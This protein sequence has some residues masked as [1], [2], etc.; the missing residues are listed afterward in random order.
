MTAIRGIPIPRLMSAG[1]F[2][3]RHAGD[4]VELIDGVVVE[5]PMPFSEH[6]VL[7]F[8]IAFALGNFVIPRDLG[9]I[10]TND[11]FVRTGTNPDR[12]RGADVAYY[13]YQRLPKGPIPSIPEV[14][15]ELV[16]EV[17]SPSDSWNE[18]H[19]KIGEYLRDGVLTALVIDSG[20]RTIMVCK[21]LSESQSLGQDDALILPDILPG[22]TM[23][24]ARLFS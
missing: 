18:V 6:G 4:H 20:T 14:P 15:P 17:R 11:S 13:S 24:V 2:A 8:Q 3:E 12:V 5:S 9:R 23:P 16:V 21:S 22:F 10:L 7:C 19:A 1:E